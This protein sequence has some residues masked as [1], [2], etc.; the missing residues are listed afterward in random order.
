MLIGIWKWTLGFWPFDFWYGIMAF[1]YMVRTTERPFKNQHPFI[2]QIYIS[3][4]I[5]IHIFGLIRIF[6]LKEERK[7]NWG[8]NRH[9]N[10]GPRIFQMILL[11][12]HYPPKPIFSE[13]LVRL[14]HMHYSKN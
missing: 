7:T 6:H 14:H 3:S 12:H 13:T 9:W 8:D 5:I 2:I 1:P 10:E 4:I 11:F